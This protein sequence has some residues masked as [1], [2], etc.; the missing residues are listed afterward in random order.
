MRTLPR[1]M[2]AAAVRTYNCPTVDPEVSVSELIQTMFRER[3]TGYPVAVGEDI[4]G[5]VTLE[6]ARAVRDV[7]RDAYRVTDVMTTE[8]YTVS[9]DDDVMTALTELDEND[10]G[11]LLVLDEDER[12]HGLLTRTDIMTALTIIKS[13]PDYQNGAEESE[14]AVFRPQS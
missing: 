4:V 8:L 14:A 3:H 9:P 13:S 1:A 10:V 5:L 7:E 11:R 2:T 12:F 6:D